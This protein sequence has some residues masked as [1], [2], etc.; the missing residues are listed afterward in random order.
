MKAANPGAVSV[1]KIAKG[2]PGELTLSVLQRC[3]SSLLS[4]P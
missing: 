2:W 3:R 1:E 4:P